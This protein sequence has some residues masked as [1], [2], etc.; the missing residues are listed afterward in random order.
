MNKK[1][2][3]REFGISKY[4][5]I[6]RS[7]LEIARRIVDEYKAPTVLVTDIS[8]LNNQMSLY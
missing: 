6:K 3:K 4:E 8:K 1:Q 5:A 2:I 7:Q